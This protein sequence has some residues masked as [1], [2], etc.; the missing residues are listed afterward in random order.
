MPQAKLLELLEGT[1]HVF[2]QHF[3][4]YNDCIGIGDGKIGMD[5][6]IVPLRHQGLSL[7][8]TTDVWFVRRSQ[9]AHL[10]NSFSTRL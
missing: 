6:S 2:T 9:P 5:C 7:I 3:E 8:S 10:L 4:I 1:F